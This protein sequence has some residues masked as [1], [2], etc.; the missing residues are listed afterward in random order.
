MEPNNRLEGVTYIYDKHNGAPVGKMYAAEGK[1]YW[2]GQ[3]INGHVLI[4]NAA[5]QTVYEIDAEKNL[6]IVRNSQGEVTACINGETGEIFAREFKPL[7][8]AV[9]AE[10]A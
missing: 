9:L 5:D 7:T 3:G 8:Q 10:A 2:G 1:L 6:H 4:Q